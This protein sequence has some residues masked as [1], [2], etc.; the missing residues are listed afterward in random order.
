M[1]A[2]KLKVVLLGESSVG[3]SSLVLRF[4]RGDF[5]ENSMPTVGA[6]FLTQTLHVEGRTLKLEIW[7]TAGQEKFAALAP[8]YYHGAHIAILAYDIVEPSSFKKAQFWVNELQ[9]HGNQG[10]VIA[11]VGNKMDLE[12]KRAVPK[13]EAESYARANNFV[14]MET[15]AKSGANVQDVFVRA[16]VRAAEQAQAAKRPTIP[17]APPSVNLA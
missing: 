4:V 16:A 11:L 8:L 10:I 3:K 9:Q 15:S 2:V 1:A 5:V 13:E 12:S 17:A 7:D 14:F 6:A